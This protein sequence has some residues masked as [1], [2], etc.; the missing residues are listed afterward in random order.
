MKILVCQEL[1]LDLR[2]PPERDLASRRVRAEWS[3]CR[4]KPADARALDLA[5]SLRIGRPEIEIILVH[6]G[7]QSADEWLREGLAKGADRAVRIWDEEAAEARTQGAAVILA[8]AGAALECDLALLGT[9]GPLGA[10]GQ[11]GV[12]V[13]EA[14]GT[15]CVTQA[16]D[17]GWGEGGRLLIERSL[18][19]GWRERVSA[20]L[21]AVVTVSP[22]EADT[23]DIP[24]AAR[25][26]AATADITVWSL[27]DLGVP[28]ARI[29][30]ADSALHTTLPRAP[31]PKLHPLTAPD[32]SLP[33]F[34]RILKLVRGA[35]T[36]R[37]ERLV[38]AGGEEAA[39]EL[40]QLLRDEGWLDHLRRG[41]STVE[42]HLRP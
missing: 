20:P 21:P 12:L 30:Q 22:A 38:R 7:P 25:L 23:R 35:V 26:R 13:A 29:R 4:V 9:P 37:E 39:E 16:G 31:R 18:V 5:L 36:R 27:A 2:V 34:D 14:L 28:L 40:F 3:V 8:A 41:P 19:R 15:C 17:I 24:V 11:I 1:G 6:L 33:A 32:S 42:S 10:G